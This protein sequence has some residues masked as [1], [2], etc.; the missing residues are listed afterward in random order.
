MPVDFLSDEQ[1]AAYGGYIGVPTQ[2]DLERLFFLDGDDL[3][4]IATRRG[5]HNRPGI[6]LQ[7]TTVR[8]L[9]VGSTSLTCSRGEPPRSFAVGDMFLTDMFPE[10]SAGLK[11]ASGRSLRHFPYAARRLYAP[12]RSPIRTTDPQALGGGAHCRG[13]TSPVW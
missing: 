10:G 1:A 9:G 4:L 7:V 3:A 6:A 13:L 2:A 11:P 8:Y 12:C 5:D